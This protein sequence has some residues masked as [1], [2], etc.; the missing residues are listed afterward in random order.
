MIF[1]TCILTPVV[2]PRLRLSICFS[3]ALFM[4]SHRSVLIV[5]PLSILSTKVLGFMFASKLE[6]SSSNKPLGIPHFS[7]LYFFMNKTTDF[8]FRRVTSPSHLRFIRRI[9]KTSFKNVGKVPFNIF[10]LLDISRPAVQIMYIYNCVFI[11][12]LNNKVFPLFKVRFERD[13]TVKSCTYEYN[14]IVLPTV[15]SI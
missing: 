8:Y 12:C 2:T 3:F 4:S 13:N 1:K 6:L 15:R 5:H 11:L 9:K 7:L 10:L 14:F